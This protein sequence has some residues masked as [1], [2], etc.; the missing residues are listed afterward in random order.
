[1][2]GK[3]HSGEAGPGETAGDRELRSRT[4]EQ[5]TDMTRLRAEI[6]RELAGCGLGPPLTSVLRQR[7]KDRKHTD[8]RTRSV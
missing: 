1:M 8:E 3:L 2:S 5:R 7:R 6:D 4:Q